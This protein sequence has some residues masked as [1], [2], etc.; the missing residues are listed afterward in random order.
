MNNQNQTAKILNQNP[1]AIEYRNFLSDVNDAFIDRAVE[2]EILGTALIAEENA[3]LVGPPGT[4]KSLLAETFAKALQEKYFSYLITRYT[5][6]DEVLGH[7]SLKELKDNDAYVRQYQNKLPDV[8]IAFLDEVFKASSS[9]LNSLLTI[10]NERKIDLGNGI[11]QKTPLRMVIGASNEY[12]FNDESLGALWDRWIF[13]KHV[14][15][16]DKPDQVIRLITDKDIGKIASQLDPQCVDALRQQRD[17]VDLTD[18]LDDIAKLHQFLKAKGIY[19]SPRRW[20]KV[21]K[22]IKS[23]S[24]MAGR[25]KAKVED[26]RILSEVLWNKPEQRDDI[27]GFLAELCSS[28]LLAVIKLHDACIEVLEEFD[29]IDVMKREIE[30]GGDLVI[31]SRKKKVIENIHKDIMQYS[32]LAEPEIQRYIAKVTACLEFYRKAVYHGMME[33][34]DALNSLKSPV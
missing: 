17:Q 12:P 7:F 23:R 30:N 34:M 27:T 9:L 8:S 19:I 4:G 14:N 15:G 25:Q 31:F 21:A 2:I 18:V 29:V 3:V 10:L 26:M 32:H 6:P 33:E 5:T 1:T 28:D 22:V 13:R 20:G 16:L 24:V 11:R